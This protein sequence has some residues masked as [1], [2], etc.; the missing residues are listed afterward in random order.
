[1]LADQPPGTQACLQE[2][3]LASLAQIVACR[4]QLAAVEAA[5]WPRTYPLAVPACPQS[6]SCHHESTEHGCS[7][8]CSS[9]AEEPGPRFARTSVDT[10]SSVIALSPFV[11]SSGNAF[12][13]DAECKPQAHRIEV[14]DSGCGLAGGCILLQSVIRTFWRMQ[15][16]LAEHGSLLA[17]LNPPQKQALFFARAF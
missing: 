10:F 15:S 8:F 2:G 4:K 3:S 11:P 17:E 12:K 16:A 7:R 1:M 9:I 13:P 14:A 6:T 5:A